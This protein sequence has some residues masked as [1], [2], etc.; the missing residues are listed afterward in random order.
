MEN[1]STPTI[2]PEVQEDLEIDD[3]ISNGSLAKR[4][5]DV[6]GLEPDLTHLFAEAVGV[7]PARLNDFF[8]SIDYAKLD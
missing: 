4:I 8:E 2:A 1:D 6:I 7:T 3:S 5:F